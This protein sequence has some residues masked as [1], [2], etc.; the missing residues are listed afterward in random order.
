MFLYLVR[1]GDAKSE[2]E[3]PLRPLSDRGEE[4]VRRVAGFL[5]GKGIRVMQIFHS[6]KLRAGQTARILADY[7]KPVR[8]MQQI[9]GLAPMDD[10]MIWSR[11]LSSMHD[12]VMLVG[13]L[14]Y[15]SM[16][17]GL[18]LSGGKGKHQLDYHSGG[19]ACLKRNSKWHLQWMI[20]PG[21]IE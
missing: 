17:S 3:N 12:D 6:A 4:D 15:L 13:H 19:V 9:D 10:P 2:E 5:V 8:D 18:L 14:P 1:H 20:S 16:L 7:L 11:R 21:D